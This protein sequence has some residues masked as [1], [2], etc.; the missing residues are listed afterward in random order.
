LLLP[1]CW[2]YRLASSSP[3]TLLLF[4]LL[5]LPTCLQRKPRPFLSLYFL[6]LW[7]KIQPSATRIMLMMKRSQ[8]V[9]GWEMLP[10]YW[11]KVIDWC[12]LSLLL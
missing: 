6:V 1:E 12:G 10:N 11:L 9:V 3:A 8:S 2:D 7:T 5:T 4:I